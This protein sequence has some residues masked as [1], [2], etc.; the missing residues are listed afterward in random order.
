M[1]QSDLTRTTSLIV[2]VLATCVF[3]AP[4]LAS[5]Q[6][7]PASLGADKDRVAD[8]VRRVPWHGSKIKGSPDPPSAYA[9]E[10]AFPKLKFSFPV[11]LVPAAG[12]NRLFL[13]EL[14]GRIYSFPE[15]PNCSK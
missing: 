5:D 11:V 12:T 15:D 8:E 2:A 14:K 6:N 9:A 1:I 4:L 10:L 13:G 3:S 7:T